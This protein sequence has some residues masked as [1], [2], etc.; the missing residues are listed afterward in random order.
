MPVGSAHYA[1]PEIRHGAFRVLPRTDGQWAVLDERL[2]P[3]QRTIHITPK[4]VDAEAC[5]KTWHAQ[6]HG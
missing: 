1:D 5:A 4:K 2:P 3:G 6:G